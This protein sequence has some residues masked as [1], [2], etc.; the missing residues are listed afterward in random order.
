MKSYKVMSNRRLTKDTFVLRTER[1][2]S[3]II[4]GQC[5]SVGINS[6]G[7]NREYSMYSGA[8]D[9]FVDFLI[10]KVEGGALSTALSNLNEGDF[11]E[12]GGP[13]GEFRLDPT[14][15]GAKRFVFISTGTGI[16]PFHSFCQTYPEL[17]YVLLHGIRLDSEKYDYQDY[18]E[19]RY[20]AFVSKPTN[21]VSRQYVT[22]ALADRDLFPDELYYLCGNRNMITDCTAI[23]RDKGIHGDSIYTETFF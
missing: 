22:Q 17:D 5:F 19:G 10:R 23:L 13:Y 15:F 3:K 2:E 20:F 6:L 21:T 12:V 7:I 9:D 11:V 16:A 8:E 18:E 1:P 14:S 4:A